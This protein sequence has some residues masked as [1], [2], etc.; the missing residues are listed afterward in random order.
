MNSRVRAWCRPDPR[1]Q[2]R[3]RVSAWLCTALVFSCRPV[4][5]PPE[6]TP[7]IVGPLVRPLPDGESATE[8]RDSTSKRGALPDFVQ[9]AEKLSP[10]VV[11]VVSTVR[12]GNAQGGR[13]RG[14][15]SGLIVSSE[16]QILTNE[17]VVRN[18][19]RVEVELHRQRSVAA[20]IVYAD[21][22]LDLALLEVTE[23]VAGLIPAT[24]REKPP[25][26]GEWVMALGQ[27]FAL[28]NTV[29]VGVVSGLRRNYGDL[30]RPRDLASDG[31][32]SF[33]QTDASI[34]VGNSGGP[35]VDL[36]GEVVGVTTAVRADGQGL[37][38]AIPAQ[39]A[40][41]FVEEVRAHGRMRHPRLGIRAEN[42]GPGAFPG[43]M[44]VVRVT[45][46]ERDGAAAQ[47][48]LEAGDLV[49]RVDDE[50]V[51]RV[52]ELVWAAQLA[53]VDATLKLHVGRPDGSARDVELRAAADD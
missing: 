2:V 15:G 29:T 38:F 43:R 45:K 24:L 32:W 33:I 36:D 37:A 14:I 4:E 25:Q 5:S 23:P 9:L 30:G 47:A 35:L 20:K 10:S 6:E 28:G 50:R 52:S 49:L 34:N 44:A 42:A 39:M 51:H 18:A 19:A 40:A 46:V 3:S 17:H 48:G 12:I 53:G 11:S 27:P 41:R 21:P 31:T 16:G 1:D 22:S 13:L 26:V 8:D 7:P